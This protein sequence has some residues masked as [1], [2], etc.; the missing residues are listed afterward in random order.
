MI[1]VSVTVL[2]MEKCYASHNGVN[3]SHTCYCNR[4]IIPQV[5]NKSVYPKFY[6]MNKSN[7]CREM[8]FMS[9]QYLCLYPNELEFELLHV[10]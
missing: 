4:N 2:Q 3:F 6:K 8:I 10:S 9:N 5:N 7:K 1:S